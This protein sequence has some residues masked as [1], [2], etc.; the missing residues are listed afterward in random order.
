L[1]IARRSFL[2]ASLA[3][4]GLRAASE[5]PVALPPDHV[6]AAQ[7]RRRIAVQYDAHDRHLLGQID[8]NEWLRYLFT[9]EDQP[10]SEIDTILWDI[11]FGGLNYAVWPSRMMRVT[12]QSGLVA[13]R[14]QGFEWVPA[15]LRE[16]RKR[17]IEVFWNHR[18]SEIDVPEDSTSWM[19][20]PRTELKAAHPDWLIKSWYWPGLWNVAA[21][22][23]QDRVLAMLREIAST[24]DVDGVRIDFARHMPVLPPGRQ[25]EMR[26]A[27]T[28][29][30]RRVRLMLLEEA[31][32]RGRPLL[33]GAKVPETVEGCRIDG[34]DVTEWARQNLVDLFTL[35]SRTMNVD[36]EGFRRIVGDKPI[37]L[38]P[39]FDDYHATDGYQNHSIEL[40]RGVFSN[41]WAQGADS[42][43]TFNWASA[44]RPLNPASPNTP[45]SGEI[46]QQAYREVGSPERMRY[47]SKLFA[48]ERRGGYPWSEGYFN[49]NQTAPLPYEL[50]NDGRAGVFTV[51]VADDA[52]AAGGRLRAC[53]LH[54]DLLR[55]SDE[56]RIDVALNGVA[57]ANPR[58]DPNWTDPRIFS[59]RQ[60]N[61]G[62]GV[63]AAIRN[64]SP[65]PAK[66]TRF[67]YPAPAR[68]FRRGKNE[69]RVRV[70]DRGRYAPGDS[71][72]IEKMEVAFEYHEV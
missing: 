11:G 1:P 16:C 70:L 27:A 47:K 63:Y 50:A 53:M 62:S 26:G 68:L 43:E 39:C 25:W 46:Q 10:G 57:L 33:L 29:F 20:A 60:P 67:T 48:V 36:V 42:V 41:W 59:T 69:V 37:R 51:R 13:W 38:Q 56:D 5:A 64:K 49:L 23:L 2:L 32:K 14:K 21:P 8:P 71:L 22:G 12:R 55:A 66:L 19:K 30:M 9:Y 3:A 4:P 65:Q 40:F 6:K 24:L 72:Q 45:N 31:R 18:F 28:A 17:K 35:G 15:L 52:A 7:R 54:V 44:P 34:L 58:R 61:A